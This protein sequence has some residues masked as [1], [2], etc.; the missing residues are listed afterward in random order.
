MYTKE[1]TEDTVKALAY[2]LSRKV[3]L[4]ELVIP[5]MNNGIYTDRLNTKQ[6]IPIKIYIT[7]EHVD[8]FSTVY[9]FT[10]YVWYNVTDPRFTTYCPKFAKTLAY[11]N[12]L[13][14][15]PMTE[16]A[17]YRISAIRGLSK[18]ILH[19][20]SMKFGTLTTPVMIRRRNPVTECTMEEGDL[21][22]D[23]TLQ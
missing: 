1:Q 16:Y 20:L 12:H 10:A 6:C 17:T 18:T 2:N 21:F 9:K 3:R 23:Q 13:V 7:K 4:F 11:A 14:T 22:N 8:D 15:R 5:R 19:K